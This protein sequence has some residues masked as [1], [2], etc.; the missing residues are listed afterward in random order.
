MAVGTAPNAVPASG[1]RGK[2][3]LMVDLEKDTLRWEVSAN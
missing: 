1:D 3:C 2:P